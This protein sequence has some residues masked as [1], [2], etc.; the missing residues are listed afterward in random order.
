[1]ADER[2]FY[3]HVPERCKHGLPKDAL[4][5]TNCKEC[6]AEM[7]AVIDMV[8]KTTPRL[9]PNFRDTER[10]AREEYA[11]AAYQINEEINQGILFAWVEYYLVELPA[12]MKAKKKI[13]LLEAEREG[14][15]S[16][17]HKLYWEQIQG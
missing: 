15:I 8:S 13:G 9:P 16:E 17:V 7:K 11:Q 3:E 4:G 1:M 6:D 12:S 10:K 14:R 2:K 5:Y